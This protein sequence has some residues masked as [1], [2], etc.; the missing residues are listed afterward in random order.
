ME[1]VM[2]QV[3][4][5]GAHPRCAWRWIR[6]ESNQIAISLKQSQTIRQLAD[7]K[8]QAVVL[9]CDC[10]TGAS[11]GPPFVGLENADRS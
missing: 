7:H 10:G 8:L 3:T 1:T 5:C 2:N 11:T 6:S 4:A 9:G